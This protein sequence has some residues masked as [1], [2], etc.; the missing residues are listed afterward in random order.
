ML[1][2]FPM[3]IINISKGSLC[4]NTNSNSCLIIDIIKI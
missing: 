2:L 1:F 3:D 4:A